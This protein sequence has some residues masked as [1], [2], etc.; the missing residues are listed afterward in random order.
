M[1]KIIVRVFI[2]FL[3]LALLAVL[4]VHFFLDSAIKR[5]VETI[6]PKLT[7]VEVKLEGVSLSLLTGAGKIKGL[8]IGNPAGFKSPSAIQV[9]TASLA[10]QPN[11]LLSDKIII[12]SIN[13]QAPE[14]T[15]ESDLKSVNLKKILANL[16]ESTG[17]SAKEPSKPKANGETTS[18]EQKKLQ[19]DQFIISGGKVHVSIT[20][21][22]QSA[23]VPLPEIHLA[24]LGKG[25]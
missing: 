22:G 17:G 5:G 9:G 1:K 14:V 18:K 3:V 19:V 4:A 7:K 8:V 15:F 13:V 24:D 11:S 21:L 10:L 20:P 25:P 16:E 2:G 6:G 12:K 23:T